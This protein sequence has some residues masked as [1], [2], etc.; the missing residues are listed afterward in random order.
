[1]WNASDWEYDTSSEDSTSVAVITGA[2]GKLFFV[3]TETDEHLDFQYTV[4]SVGA[5]KGAVFNVAKSLV[6]TP[7]GGLAKLRQR[8]G[9]LFNVHRFPCKGIVIAGGLTAGVFTPSFIDD[10][11]ADVAFLGFGLDPLMFAWVPVWGC[12]SSILPSAGVS[13][14]VISCQQARSYKVAADGLNSN[15]G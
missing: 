8:P 14:G 11:G 10:S 15:V 3:N 12:F 9:S 2:G 6:T 7:S 5:A 13:V 1:M 4:L